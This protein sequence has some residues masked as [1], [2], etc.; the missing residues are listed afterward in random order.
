MKQN[1]DASFILHPSSFGKGRGGVGLD[2][3]YEQIALVWNGV[4]DVVYPPC[5]LVCRARLEAGALC[6]ECTH[7]F[8]PLLPPYCDRCGIPIP[9]DRSVC[10]VCEAG[11]EP[12]YAWSQALGQYTGALR[13]AIHRLKYD[14]K[15]AL[16]EPLGRLLARSLDDPPSPLLH[17]TLALN[18]VGFDRVVPVPLHPSRLRRRGF[19]QAERIAFYLA[20]ERGWQ[21]DTGG[22]IRVKSARSQTA[23]NL[24]DRAVNVRGA[25]TV[26]PATRYTGKTVLIVDDVLTTGSTAGEAARAVRDAGAARVCVVALARGI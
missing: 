23:L 4:L 14:G 16:A 24:S 8:V 13:A 26:R 22:L 19:N 12:P 7:S 25:F 6:D 21:L 11:P 3:L 9:A 17:P 5:C 20:R 18:P 1:S 15:T 2:A 10:A